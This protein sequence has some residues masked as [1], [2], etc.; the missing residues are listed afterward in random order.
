MDFKKPLTEVW[1][2]PPNFDRPRKRAMLIV[3]SSKK[4]E[5]KGSF[6]PSFSTPLKIQ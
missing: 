2:R 4:D 1:N 5:K 6:E 3:I